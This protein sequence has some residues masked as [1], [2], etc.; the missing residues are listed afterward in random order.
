MPRLTDPLK[1]TPVSPKPVCTPSAARFRGGGGKSLPHSLLTLNCEAVGLPELNRIV[2]ESHIDHRKRVIEILHDSTSYPTVVQRLERLKTADGGKLWTEVA[3]LLKQLRYAA[4]TFTYRVNEHPS[5]PTQ[6]LSDTI[7]TEAYETDTATAAVKKATDA[8]PALT[9]DTVSTHGHKFYASIKTNLLYDALLVPTIGAELYLGRKWS[10]SAQWSYAWW[11]R[12][13]R[14]KYWRYYGGD[15]SIRRWIGH[16]AE[17]KPLTGHHIGLYAQLL[18]YD[19]ENGGKGQMGN[20]FNYG[21]GIEY[22]YSLAVGSRLNFDFTIGA[23]YIGGSYYEYIPVDGHYVW[24]ATRRRHWIGPT[25]AEVSLVWLI[26]PGNRN[27]E[28]GGRP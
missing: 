22:G 7:A 23:G 24:Q 3:P 9:Y 13:R 1:L 5:R 19:F 8:V 20:K 16:A 21:G 17:T 2:D 11:S 27:A 15:L 4:V 25:K 18:T 10:L 26:G 12:N 6:H 14:H 28:K